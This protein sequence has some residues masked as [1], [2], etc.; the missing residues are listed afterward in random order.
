MRGI[1]YRRHPA[2]REKARAL[3]K[4]KAQPR[5]KSPVIAETPV[6]DLLT[7]PD[8]VCFLFGPATDGVSL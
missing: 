3:R 5:V 6:S 7:A 1:A 8:R 2:A 4:L